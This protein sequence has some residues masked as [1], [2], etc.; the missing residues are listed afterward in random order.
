MEMA[1]I[2]ATLS[3][4]F[5]F[6]LLEDKKIEMGPLMTLRTKEDVMVKLSLRGN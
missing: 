4:K 5:K 1:L 6:S 3:Q 2:L